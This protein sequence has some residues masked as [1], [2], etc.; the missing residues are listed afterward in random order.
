MNAGANS[1]TLLATEML[2][3]PLDVFSRM[4]D[5]TPELAIA[6]SVMEKAMA[7]AGPKAAAIAIDKVAEVLSMTTPGDTAL[8]G[9]IEVLES[10]PSDLL[11]KATD[12]ILREY[13]WPVLPKPADWVI[14]IQDDL[15][16]RNHAIALGKIVQRRWQMAR[17]LYPQPTT[18]K[19]G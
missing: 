15:T 8:R 18:P 5:P 14:R 9:Y 3:T 1:L 7:P 2:A 6:I 19:A 13:V 17:K 12:L 4:L 16:K 10:I 11:V